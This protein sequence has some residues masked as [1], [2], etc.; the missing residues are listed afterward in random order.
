MMNTKKTLMK[1]SMKIVT[2]TLVV[3]AIIFSPVTAITG[4][5]ASDRSPLKKEGIAW[6][7]KMQELY[8]TLADLLT[9]ISSAKRFGDPANRSRIVMETEKL[10]SLAHDLNTKGVLSPDAD[11]TIPLV[12]GLLA[13][14]TKRAALEFKKGN[15]AYARNLLQT[16]PGYC[17]ACHTRNATG[18]QFAQLAF[19]PTSKSLTA[20][21]RG[22]FFAATRQFDR[23]Q[24][25]FIQVIKDPKAA[26]AYN[27][28]WEKAIH[29]SL[30]IAVRVKQDS[31]Q[32]KEIVQ[33]ALNMKDAP[34]S[35]KEDAKVWKTSIQEW[36]EEPARGSTSEEGL[37][38]EA[39][40]LMAKARETQKYPM[41]RT[42]DVLYLRASAIVHD[43]LQAAPQGVYA[44]EALLLAGIS[45]EVLSPLKTEDLHDL[46]YEACIRRSP[47]TPTS[48]LC[49]RRYE[50]SI[51]FG[52]TGSAGTDVPADVREKL[53]GLKSMSQ[54]APTVKP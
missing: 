54:P 18:P 33:I 28:D 10:A 25:E 22:E 38:S 45:Y 42:A 4:E 14:E 40:R 43:L 16:V 5:S 12:A 24:T 27:F 2:G 36:Q 44:G 32:A 41:D 35:I 48:D 11:P 30:A 51:F 15:R 50:Q 8:K 17:I 6:S 23:A 29:Q 37:H 34:S 21:E 31:S 1:S 7:R 53:I 52:Y 20:L 46:Y 9:D 19:E 13:Q 26:A 3:G 49:Y 39:L 47:H